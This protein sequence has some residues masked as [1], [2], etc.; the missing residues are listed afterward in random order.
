MKTFDITRDLEYLNYHV[1]LWIPSKAR[2]H[3][4]S[5]SDLVLLDH[6]LETELQ[7]WVFLPMSWYLR[8]HETWFLSRLWCFPSEIH[9]FKDTDPNLSRSNDIKLSLFQ[10]HLFQS[11]SYIITTFLSFPYFLAPRFHSD[12]MWIRYTGNTVDSYSIR[13]FWIYIMDQSDHRILLMDENHI[14]LSRVQ[15]GLF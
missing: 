7:E 15:K 4:L 11:N 1:S 3:I 6:K 14:I 10:E 2:F 8:C 5:I 9:S 12:S 13:C